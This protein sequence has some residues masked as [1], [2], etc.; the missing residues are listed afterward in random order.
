MNRSDQKK[1]FYSFIQYEPAEFL[2]NT[3]TVITPAEDKASL[4]LIELLFHGFIK[5]FR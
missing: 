4:L 3:I 2:L 1:T 5:I